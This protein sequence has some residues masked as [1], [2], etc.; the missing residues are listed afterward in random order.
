MTF[1]VQV[2]KSSNDACLCN[3]VGIIISD[4]NEHIVTFFTLEYADDIF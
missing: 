3:V 1:F 2:E 4:I